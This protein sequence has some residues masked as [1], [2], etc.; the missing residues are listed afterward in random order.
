MCLPNVEDQLLWS[1]FRCTYFL[2]SELWGP[3]PYVILGSC[4]VTTGV[5]VFLLPETL[6]RPLPDTVQQA[7]AM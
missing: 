2:Q 6:G 1:A 5:L 3:L 4:A 7:Q